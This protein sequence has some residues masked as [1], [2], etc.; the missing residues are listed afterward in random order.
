MEF[1][2]PK[3]YKPSSFGQPSPSRNE[4]LKY[5]LGFESGLY[6]V[7][8][9]GLQYKPMIGD[10]LFIWNNAIIMRIP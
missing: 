8:V 3:T 5:E 7:S 9:C 4:I 10:T 2:G 1:K 6:I